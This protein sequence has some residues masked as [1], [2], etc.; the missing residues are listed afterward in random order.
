MNKKIIWVDVG[1]HQAQ[2]YNSVFGKN[3]WFIYRIFRMLISTIL[4]RRKAFIGFKKIYSLI[5]T[6]RKIR[7]AQSEFR[8][9]FI[10]AN[11]S[12]ICEKIYKLA[13]D[14]FCIALGDKS[15]SSFSI[16]RLYHKNQDKNSQGNTIYLK[17]PGISLSNFTLCPIVSADSFAE[18][19]KKFLDTT[20]EDY[21]IILRINCE[22]SEDAVI[23]AF[24]KHFGEKFKVILGSLKDVRVIKGLDKFEKLENHLLLNNITLTSFSSEVDSWVKAHEVLLKVLSKIK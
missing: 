5:L 16:N 18:S 9:A 14:I 3:S 1:T 8:V 4:L 12:H 2:E 24:S 7:G 19:Y 6:R 20:Y 22:G 21:E 10:E 15:K 11:P 13:S 17:T 23:Y